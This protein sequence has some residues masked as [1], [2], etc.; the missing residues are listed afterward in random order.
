MIP[1]HTD[2]KIYEDAIFS[3]IYKRNN[4]NVL[5]LYLFEKQTVFLAQL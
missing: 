2:I 3:L 4:R 1:L 5:F